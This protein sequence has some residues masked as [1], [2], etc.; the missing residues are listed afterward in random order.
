MGDPMDEGERKSE[1]MAVTG[2]GVALT[3]IR[4]YLAMTPTERLRAWHSATRLA[5]ELQ[6]HAPGLPDDP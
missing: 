3:L 2:S 4:R 5:L 1:G 6:R